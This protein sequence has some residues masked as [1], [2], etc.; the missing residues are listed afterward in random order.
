M[1]MVRDVAHKHTDLAVVDLAPVAAP[2]ALHAHRMRAALGKTAG[3]EGDD[4]IGLP[5]SLGH[6]ANQ[7][8]EQRAMSPRDGAD[9]VLDDLSLHIDERRNVLS[10]FAGQVRQEPLEV[11]MQVALAGL[12]LQR[13][14][15]GYNELTQTLH[16][17]RED[18]GGDET[19]AQDF[20]S[21]LGPHGVH[22][23]A[24][25]HCSVDTECCL[26]AM[27]ITTCY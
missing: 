25:S 9:E 12:G 8:G 18:V 20:L 3:I 1:V 26:E 4:A 11:E 6:L 21:P 19:I 22:L 5:Q 24:S 7:H 23:F 10:I 2:L 15:V 14:L 13:V 27:V 16:H 17:L